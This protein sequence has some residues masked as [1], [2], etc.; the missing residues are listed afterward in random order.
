[1]SNFNRDIRTLRNCERHADIDSDTTKQKDITGNAPECAPGDEMATYIPLPANELAP[2][3]MVCR[4]PWGAPNLQSVHVPQNAA[5]LAAV[6]YAKKSIFIQTPNLNAEPLLPELIAAVKRKVS[7]TYYVCLG[8]ND[9]VG[10]PHPGHYHA[11][12]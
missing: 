7:V 8:Y 4:K 6:K 12:M 2:M 11:T 10:G 1:M 9:A 5:F 3:A